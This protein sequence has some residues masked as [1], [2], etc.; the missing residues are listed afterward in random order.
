MG[1]SSAKMNACFRPVENLLS[2]GLLSKTIRNY[3]FACFFYGCET[4]SPTLREERRLS[5]F[6]NRVLRIIF[7]PNSDKVTKEWRKL[8]NEELYD[9][10][11]SPR[12]FWRIKSRRMRWAGHVT[13]M[14]ERRSEFR[15]LV[16]KPEVKR[17]LRKSRRRWEYNIKMHLQ[18]V[19]CGGIDLIE[20]YQDRDRWLA[21]VNAVMNLRVP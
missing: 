10:N 8:H 18:E 21:P 1:E 3:N 13:R 6:K 16:G 20:L 11:I 5:V 19:G 14:G 2:S 12:I 17:P 4:W 7:G 9:L 15:V